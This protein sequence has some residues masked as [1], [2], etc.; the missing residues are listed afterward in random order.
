MSELTVSA[1][2]SDAAPDALPPASTRWG[3]WATCAWGV[4]AFGVFYATQ[5]AVMIGLLKWWPFR[6]GTAPTTLKALE[7]NA[8]IV[9]MTTIVCVPAVVLF[10][11]LAIRFARVRF[12][13]YLA[14]KPV[15][16]RTTL[17]ALAATLGY[18][19]ALE[20][21]TWLA[22][23]PL[24]VPFVTELYQSA[25]DT[26]TLPLVL[27][28]VAVAAPIT[29]ETL[30][31]GFVLRGWASSRLGPVGAVALTSAI[32]AGIHIQY[33]WVE[34]SEIFGLGLLLGYVRLRS[35]SLLPS[36]V[37]H[38]AY[39]LAAMIQGAILGG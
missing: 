10:L 14:L 15:D 21:V 26:A 28:A 19:A 1:Q 16:V 31:R 32:W 8:V 24:Q 30:F 29:E 33:D 34:V 37:A 4:G 27:I 12:V 13:D 38:G 11:A 36:M 25:R 23:R 22:G 18:G 35:G 7:S 9:S 2:P 6:A 39:G 3:F 20:V 17:R 5:A